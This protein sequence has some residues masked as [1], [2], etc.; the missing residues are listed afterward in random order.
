MSPRERLARRV[1]V[2][3]LTIAVIAAGLLVVYGV[4]RRAIRDFDVD[5]DFDAAAAP[6]AGNNATQ[7]DILRNARNALEPYLTHAPSRKRHALFLLV[8]VVLINSL[9]RLLVRRGAMLGAHSTRTTEQSAAL[10]AYWA[11]ATANTMGVY[12]L[13]AWGGRARTSAYDGARLTRWYADVGVYLLATLLWEA[14][15]PPAGAL[16]RCLF[17]ADARRELERV[18]AFFGR[19]RTLRESVTREN[20]FDERPVSADQNAP[21][22]RR[23]LDQYVVAPLARFV[24]APPWD[25]TTRGAD[26]LRVFFVGAVFGAGQPLLPVLSAATLS[27]MLAHDKWALLRERRPPPRLGPHLA[28]TAAA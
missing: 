2:R 16:V 12:A 22:W 9:L 1:A 21:A 23:G 26:M 18:R 17:R 3:V 8:V 14:L 4:R 20:L 6:P 19:R 13:A 27:V 28:R 25:P 5:D 24:A 15:A 11:A 7:P 10:V